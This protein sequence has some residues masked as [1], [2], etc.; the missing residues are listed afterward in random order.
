MKELW[1]FTEEVE[2]RGE[3]FKTIKDELADTDEFFELFSF[4]GEVSEEEVQDYTISDSLW[5]VMTY[6]YG[7]QDW[8]AMKALLDKKLVDVT[9]E[10]AEA[11]SKLLEP[12]Q[13]SLISFKRTN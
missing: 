12:W 7:G 3:T 6:I 11:F 10:D 4:L 13:D 2:K 5:I 1:G 8:K 9:K